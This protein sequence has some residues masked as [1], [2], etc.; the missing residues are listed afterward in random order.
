MKKSLYETLYTAIMIVFSV[1]IVVTILFNALLSYNSFLKDKEKIQQETLNAKKELMKN[2][3]DFFITDIESSRKKLQEKTK[4]ELQKRVDVAYNIAENLY[5]TQK[6]NP[7]IQSIIIESLRELKFYD[8]GDQYVF[9]TKLDGTFLLV[10]GLK[11][12]EGKNVFNLTT[13]S[14]KKSIHDIIT[15]VKEKKEGFFEYEWQNHN[16]LVFEKKISYFKYFEPFDCYIGT[17]VFLTDI[18]EKLKQHFLAK[19]DSFRFGTTLSNYIFSASYDG[20]SYTEPAKGK[21]VYNVTDV[22]GLKVVQELIKVAKSGSGFV[23]YSIPLGKDKT[24]DKISYV[25]GIDKWQ[26]YIGFGETFK[27]INNSIEI[28]KKELLSELYKDIVTTLFLGILFSIL[29]YFILKTIKESLTT[30]INN[31]IKSICTLVNENKKIELN[32]LKFNE[33]E[34][35]A[36]QTNQLLENKIKVEATLKEKETLLYQQSKMAAMGE[37]LENIAHQWRQPLSLITISSTGIQAKKEYGQLDDK[38]LDESLENINEN[39]E[40]LSNTIDDFRNFF[41]TSVSKEYFKIDKILDK[42]LKLIHLRDKMKEVSLVKQIEP[43]EINSFKNQLLQILLVILNNAY[44][45]LENIQDVKLLFIEVSKENDLITI[46]IKDNAGGIKTEYL[47]KI[48]EPYFTTKHKTKGTGV[49]LYMA[50]EII[51]KHLQGNITVIN[52]TYTYK[53]KEYMGA[54]FI[55]TFPNSV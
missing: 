35:V 27:D 18:E 17:G 48:F 53:K 7:N 50:R 36:I 30:D 6:N 10:S 52:D 15:M 51:V 37:L 5:K 4:K 9:M 1:F 20:I 26:L 44:D 16:T 25:V 46:I 32:T 55:I 33:F 2:K 54:K 19:I 3:V 13:Q 29:F 41:V 40:Y 39:A 24:L 22:N 42:T 11:H 28:K 8:I 31:L 43:I 12:L 34:Q 47:E 21:N 23:T 38:F 14:N 45:A 49:G